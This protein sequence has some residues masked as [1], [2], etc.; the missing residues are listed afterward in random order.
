MR[1]EMVAFIWTSITAIT[2]EA[3]SLAGTGVVSLHSAFFGAFDFCSYER[4]N[5]HS[6]FDQDL[7]YRTRNNR[8]ITFRND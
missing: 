1:E 2:H 8:S 7:Y 4:F 5:F 3:L 6:L